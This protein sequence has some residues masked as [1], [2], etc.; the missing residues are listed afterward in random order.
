M[1]V[2]DHQHHRACSPRASSSDSRPSNSRAWLPWSAAGAVARGRAE[3]GSNGATA[4][5]TGSVSAGSPPRASGR[6][7]ATSGR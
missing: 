6:S 5:R 7:A 2:L 3:P 4:S 1:Q